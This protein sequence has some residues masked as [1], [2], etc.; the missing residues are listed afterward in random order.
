VLGDLLRTDLDRE[1]LLKAFMARRGERAR[2]VHDLAVQAA[3][4]QRKP[5][6]ATDL[7]ALAAKLQ[8]LVA[9]PA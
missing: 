5:E 3:R 7:P 9:E 4:W 6:A 1:A 8:R 2:A